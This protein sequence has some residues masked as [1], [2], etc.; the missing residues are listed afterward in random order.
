MR[1]KR[2]KKTTVHSA[3]VEREESGETITSHVEVRPLRFK[4][5]TPHPCAEVPTIR[6][7]ATG[8]S[9]HNMAQTQV[10]GDYLLLW[11]GGPH[12]EDYSLCKLYLVAWK[13]GSVTLV[14]SKF[15]SESCSEDIQSQRGPSFFPSLFLTLTRKHAFHVAWIHSLVY[16]HYHQY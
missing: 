1:K 9:A 14:S 4:D 6:L 12:E 2:K 15:S 16:Y 7:S 13:R 3:R 8:A 10:L 11:I 5:G